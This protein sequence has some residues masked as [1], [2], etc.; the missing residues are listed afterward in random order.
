MVRGSSN[1]TTKQSKFMNNTSLATAIT[2][3][4]LTA[5]CAK[6]MAAESDAVRLQRLE[7]AVSALQKEN[8]SLK[9]QIHSE[10]SAEVATTPA[11][12]INLSAPVSELKLYGE[13]RLRYFMNEG[14][15]AGLDAGDTGQRERLRYRM[16]LGADIKFKDNWM[17]GVLLETGN[18]SRSANVTLGENPFF[19]KSTVGTTSVVNGTAITT[20]KFVTGTDAKTG[21]LVSGTAV[22]GVSATKGA[23]V[24]SVNYGDDLF[25][26]RAF[27]KF[28][29]FDWLS[30]EGGKM[31]NPFV[32]TRMVWDPDISPE[33]LAEQ[34]KYTIG[35]SGGVLTS[36]KDAKETKSVAPLGGVTVDL[37][38]NFAQFIYQDVGF[39]N[40]FNTGTGPFGE[41]PNS[42]DRWM[43]GW[44]LGAKVNFDKNTYFQIA[45]AFY[46][47]TGGGSSSAGPFNGDNALVILDKNA[48]PALITFN[49]T[50]VNDLAV[51]DIPVEFGWRMWDVPFTL[52]GDFAN[53]FDA[54]TRAA[55][56]G[57]PDKTEGIAYQLGASIGAAKKKGDFEIRGWYQHSEQYALDQNIIDDDIFDGRLNMQGYFLQASYL[58]TDAASVILQYSH[59]SRIDENL[60]TAGFGA[61]GTP[62]GFPLQSTNFVYVDLN[63]KF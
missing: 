19:A 41:V 3:I 28:S 34:F 25:V 57:H 9:N 14:V 21:K 26:G 36:G 59:G 37:F 32:S 6:L 15:A 2:T 39:E 50:G 29:P 4:I 24:S 33:G 23:V 20:G 8:A 16:R 53:N 51:L 60:G 12:R 40:T 13:G 43:L 30:I 31:P 49:Q 1:H 27:L 11:G 38:A 7:D 55:K 18:V 44:Q 62:A 5:S 61:L 63:L 58:F 56:A 10:V 46:Q 47:Y 22:T 42:T 45:P 35:S 17:L 52:F 48:D 54:G